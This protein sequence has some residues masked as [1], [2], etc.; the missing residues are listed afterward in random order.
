MKFLCVPLLCLSILLTITVHAQTADEIVNKTI[1][2]V[3]GKDKING[4]KTLYFESDID[5]MGNTASST[6]YIVNGK[7]YRSEVDFGGQKIVNCI[8]D[9]AGWTINPMAGQATP[10][11]V[12][13]E[14]VKMS[15]L[16]LQVGGPL[17]DYA[18]KGNTVELQGTEDIGGVKAHKLKVTTKEAI[19]IS[20]WIDPATFYVLKTV[21]KAKVKEQTMETTVSFSNYQK[22][23]YGYVVPFTTETTLPQGITLNITHK[24]AEVNKDIDMT[25]FDMPKQ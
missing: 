12:P 1:E 8:T 15:Q 25:I 18:T 19:E 17:F 9:K 23:E 24:K 3:G 10:T 20:Y 11:A 6:T 7:A 22:T 16:Q 2:A 5:V 13:E 21:S 14:Q 4:I